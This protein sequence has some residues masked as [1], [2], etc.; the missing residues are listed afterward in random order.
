[1]DADTLISQMLSEILADEHVKLTGPSCETG[2]HQIRQR[3]L[4]RKGGEVLDPTWG[5]C[6]TCLRSL[7]REAESWKVVHPSGCEC[8]ECRIHWSTPATA[9]PRF[10]MSTVSTGSLVEMD[11]DHRCGMRGTM[12]NSHH[13]RWRV[14][15]FW[16]LYRKGDENYSMRHEGQTLVQ[17][18]A[19]EALYVSLYAVCGTMLRA[20]DFQAH[21]TITGHIEK[22]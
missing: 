14:D 7:M 15:G 9:A 3:T 11:P 21:A 17:C 2:Q 5:T 12:G 8:R 18:T 10:K 1:M 6:T 22:P 20:D 16:R 4:L 13:G 19:E